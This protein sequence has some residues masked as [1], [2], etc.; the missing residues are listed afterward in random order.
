MRGRWIISL[1]YLVRHGETAWNSG[2]RIQGQS[3]IPLSERG[4][5]QAEAV[6]AR[7]AGV[8]LDVLYASDLG[9]ARITGELIAGRQPRPVSVLLRPELRECDY[10]QWEGLTWSE[11]EQ[12]FPEEWRNWK[13]G[14]GRPVG[15]EDIVSLA[16]RTGR[17]FD[18]AAGNGRT[19]LISAHRGSLRTILCHALGMP[20]AFRDRF[21]I[22]NC[23]VSVLECPAGG[24][25][26]LLLL[27][28]TCHLEG[29]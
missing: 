1:I 13:A 3:D 7:L 15:G 2:K 21:D 27:N 29:V 24:R 6:A 28:D 22:A 10:G 5:R 14:S 9:R 17:L 19:V 23:S 25:A 4:M 12:R 20:Q 11:A 8:G 18:E 26:R 16:E